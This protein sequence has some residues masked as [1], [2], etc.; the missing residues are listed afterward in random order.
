MTAGGHDDEAIAQEIRQRLTWDPEIEGASIGITVEDG[1]AT[2]RG[3][4]RAYQRAAAERI[5]WATPGV[6]AVD[7]ALHLT[8]PFH[9]GDERIAALAT[10]ALA[11]VPGIPAAAIDIVVINGVVKLRGDV[12]RGEQRAAV[13][14]AVLDLPGVVD[15]RNE[16]TVGA[17]PANAGGVQGA[18]QEAFAADAA[19]TAAQIMVRV[20]GASVTLT[21]TSPTAYHRQLAERAAWRVAGVTGVR[22]ELA[23]KP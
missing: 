20:E 9:P 1:I 5:A 15:V 23:V 11:S 22:N 21:G 2:L 13:A 10:A 14:A 8:D 18:I 16:I 6:R 7:N 3:D 17:P 12:E 19:A 4:V